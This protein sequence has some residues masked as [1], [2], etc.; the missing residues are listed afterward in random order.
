[1][2]FDWRTAT[3]A[4]VDLQYSPSQFS[5]RPLDEYLQIGRAHV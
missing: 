5:K 4:E 3:D 2:P 1:M